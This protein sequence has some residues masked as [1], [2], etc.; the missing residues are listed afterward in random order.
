MEAH[1]IKKTIVMSGSFVNDVALLEQWNEW[2]GDWKFCP[3]RLQAWREANRVLPR[4]QL[5]A[6]S[7]FIPPESRRSAADEAG[8]IHNEL[9]E[10]IRTLPHEHG[11]DSIDEYMRTKLFEFLFWR[12]VLE[13][14]RE[15]YGAY[16][17]VYVPPY[18]G[19]CLNYRVQSSLSVLALL[20]QDSPHSNGSRGIA[21]RLFRRL[22][23][24]VGQVVHRFAPLFLA[25]V[26]GGGGR[27]RQAWRP[28]WYVGL[29]AADIR[30]RVGFLRV[31]KEQLGTKFGLL[32]KDREPIKLS[33]DEVSGHND[34]NDL[35]NGE[36]SLEIRKYPVRKWRIGLLGRLAGLASRDALSA[37]LKS[38]SAFTDAEAWNL[39]CRLIYSRARHTKEYFG[40]A[41][42]LKQLRPRVIIASTLVGAMYHV[43]EFARKNGVAY[44]QY[45]HGAMLDIYRKSQWDADAVV[46]HGEYERE[47]IET[48]Y[49]SQKRKVVV[50]GTFWQA[51]LEQFSWR[52]QHRTG[53]SKVQVCYL[54]SGESN[55]TADVVEEYAEDLLGLARELTDTGARLVVRM[56]PR[57]PLAE[58]LGEAVA[59][60]REHGVNVELSVGQES[61]MDQLQ[62]SRC[63]LVRKWSGAVV[64]ALYYRIPVIQWVPRE[65]SIAAEADHFSHFP[66]RAEKV[67]QVSALFKQC[68]DPDCAKAF[69]D[70]QESLL[71]RYMTGARQPADE[72]I[73]ETAKTWASL[74]SET[75]GRDH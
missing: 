56:H 59:H 10:W 24:R 34:L 69:Q 47:V 22:G 25:P 2:Y 39:S 49:P 7:T 36:G 53:S 57:A 4:H 64:Q 3:L 62:A 31:I 28:Y 61:L 66:L 74:Y 14:I 70:R 16:K 11:L 58:T 63:V 54:A 52:W 29:T 40:L 37:Q 20:I 50:G 9:H 65:L 51:Q 44:V 72:Q 43:R 33:V 26:S 38:R 18:S 42:I 32:H 23:I 55:I 48:L 17:I 6:L 35:L 13:R 73:K 5:L 41:A 27:F 1:N 21:S 45:P 67:E 71:E 15:T 68:S 8:R 12:K 75:H 46:V 60:C 19:E 30:I